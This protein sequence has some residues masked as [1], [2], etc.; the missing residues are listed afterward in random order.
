M[1][2]D[3]SGSLPTNGKTAKSNSIAEDPHLTSC[4]LGSWRPKWLQVFAHPVVF[5]VNICVVG[6]VQG[7]AGS[8]VYSNMNTVE[9]RYAFDSKISA[10]ILIADNFSGMIVSSLYFIELECGVNCVVTLQ[11]SPIVGYYG[12]RVNRSR[13][14]GMGEI[15]LAMSCFLGALPY[16]LYGP[17]THLISDDS[18]L[19]GVVNKSAFQMCN[20]HE[21]TLNCDQKGNTVWP[22]VI[23]LVTASF[24]RGFGFTTFYVIAMPFMDDNVSKKNSPIFISVMQ[25]ILLIGPAA[26]FFFSA[27]CLRFYEDPW[28][29]Y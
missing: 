5:L 8:M 23:I 20:A 18:L 1:T 3:Q 12:V 10:L 22:A 29:E 16:F 13:L 15:V 17:A 6:V 7:M 9:K 4:G 14:I 27:Y 2:F 21:S 25:T 26:G 19:S 24:F 28:S 11:L